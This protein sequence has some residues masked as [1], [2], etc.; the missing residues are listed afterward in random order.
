[1]PKQ[2]INITIGQCGIG[3]GLDFFK[4]ASIQ[5]KIDPN[6]RELN[7]NSDT[8]LENKEILFRETE[9]GK[10]FPRCI[11]LDL[12]P[13]AQINIDI[14]CQKNF[15]DSRNII[16]ESFGT[17]NSW[18]KGFQSG[19]NLESK[20]EEIVRKEIERCSNGCNISLF[21]SIGGGTGSG[22]GCSVI[23]LLNDLYPE[24]SLSS[25]CVI[26]NQSA[27]SDVVVQPYNSILSFRWLKEYCDNVFLYENE[28]IEKILNQKL[29]KNKT[30]NKQINPI[31][32]N[33]SCTMSYNLRF[34]KARFLASV[35]Q[36]NIYSPIPGLHFFFT[37]IFPLFIPSVN[38]DNYRVGKEKLE[39]Y[40]ENLSIPV[41]LKKGKL[42]SSNW[43]EEKDFFRDRRESKQS[44]N[45][46]AV[47]DNVI[48]WAP[49]P[50]IPNF[51]SMQGKNK[52]EISCN[53]MIMNHSAVL[54]IF[55]NTLKK[56]SALKRRNAF[57][58]NYLNGFSV[59]SILQL[60]EESKLCLEDLIND[61]ELCSLGE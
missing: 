51:R 49:V 16:T 30:S 26:P 10:F 44:F 57:I 41:N 59:N 50:I 31:I 2:I 37:S 27:V 19:I 52:T 8:L 21:H 43:Y 58:S 33:V 60:F 39:Y 15:L 23:E 46:E 22:L 54:E 55:K 9:C 1:M 36:Q 38:L 48:D 18:S 20:I 34:P 25:H 53:M 40:N 45:F 29:I 7:L 14:N 6:G 42:I 11:L 4:Q 5:H 28:S 24:V 47:R 13:R 56:Y 35:Q 3:V 61:Y 17:G 32:A 12:E